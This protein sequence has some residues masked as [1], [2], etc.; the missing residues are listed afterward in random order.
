M[1][2]ALVIVDVQNDFTPGG[3]LAVPGGDE[4]IAP[5]NELAA[6]GDYDLVIA[7]RDWH[8]PDH[9]SFRDH[10]G[11][12]PSHCVRDT[13]GAQLHATIDQSPIDAFIDKGTQRAAP[14]Y[15]GFEDTQLG[16]VLEREG[17][18]SLTVTGL[19]TEYCVKH[20][21]LDALRHG[22]KVT[23]PL[24]AVRGIDGADE[25]RALAEL[26]E[27]GA[28]IVADAASASRLPRS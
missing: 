8:P 27:A 9:D 2:R 10:G 15:S 20:T 14:G 1:S 23:I 28:E 25:R 24:A 26:A 13:P 5:I 18:D 11:V 22:L 12:W 6:S 16:G 17:V 3:A 7:T 19:A 21:A 4:V